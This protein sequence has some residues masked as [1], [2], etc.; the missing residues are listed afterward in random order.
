MWTVSPGDSPGEYGGHSPRN[1][2]STLCR[3]ECPHSP[4]AEPYSLRSRQ[5]EEPCFK[6]PHF[7]EPYGKPYFVRP[8]DFR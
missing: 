5:F 4:V 6:E 7:G 8:F 1:D 3:G 2:V